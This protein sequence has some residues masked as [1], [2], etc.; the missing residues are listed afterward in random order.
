MN[1]TE[2]SGANLGRI[3][4]ISEKLYNTTKEDS[5]LTGK[6]YCTFRYQ[7][8]AFT[9][10]SESSI[11][12][13]LKTRENRV[14]I[15]TIFLLDTTY[16]KINA[17]GTEETVPSFTFDGFLTV[18]E[19]LAYKE[20]TFQEAVLDAKLEAITKGSFK[21]EVELNEDALNELEGA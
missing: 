15:K 8:K 16:T 20:S 1:T 4:F 5:S 3:E 14:K 9:I 6:S 19:S 13:F 18:E 7:G 17:Q 12:P 10:P 2:I 21:P 11:I